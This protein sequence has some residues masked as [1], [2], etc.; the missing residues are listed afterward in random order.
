MSLIDS[1]TG[2]KRAVLGLACG[3]LCLLAFSARAVAQ[4]PTPSEMETVAGR[5]FVLA[6]PDTVINEHD[7]NF[8]LHKYDDQ[9]LICV[10][11]AVENKMTINGPGG[12]IRRD[13]PLAANQF[14]TIDLMKDEWRSAYPISWEVGKV[15]SSAFTVTA[16]QPVIVYCMMLTEF[17]A[18]AWTPLPVE[19]WGTV[20]YAAAR[21]G[22]WVFDLVPGK[23]GYEKSVKPA[24]GE[25][26]I[27]AAFDNTQVSFSTSE[28]LAQ[29][30]N[31]SV[32]LN[33]GQTY[34][35]QSYVNTDGIALGD[36]QPDLGGTRIVATKPISVI[37]GNT[38]AQV[39]SEGEGLTQNPW[40]N[41]LIEAVPPIEQNGTEFVFLPTWDAR[42]P[43]G[44]YL[45]YKR[46]AE[47]VRLYA[48]HNGNTEGFYTTGEPN[49]DIPI[50]PFAQSSVTEF[51]FGTVPPRYF[52]TN[53]PAMAMMNSAAAVRFNGFLPPKLPDDPDPTEPPTEPDTTVTL[54]RDYE[55]WGAYMVE[56]VP[57]EQWTTYAP[58]W[59]PAYSSDMEHYIN[60]VTDSANASSILMESG[61]P[62]FFNRGPI[63]TTGLI[64][65]TMSVIP[66]T[67]H[68]L[69][70]TNGGK[71][72]AFAYGLMRGQEQYIYIPGRPPK[73]PD[74][75]GADAKAEH[76]EYLAASYGYPLSPGR[77][78]LAAPDTLQITPTMGCT[79]LSIDVLATNANPVGLRVIKLEPATNARIKS[80]TPSMYIA[81]NVATIVVEPI[82]KSQSAS[83]TVVIIDRTGHSWSVPYS[84]VAEAVTFAPN[85]MLDFGEQ[86]VNI[87]ARRDITITNPVDKTLDITKLR[88]R[89]GNEDFSIVSSSPAVPTQLAKGA[90]MTVT[91][92]AKPTRPGRLYID[93]LVVETACTT[94]THPVRMETAEPF[95]Y[96]DDLA[97]GSVPLFGQRDLKLALCNIGRGLVTFHDSLGNDVIFWDDPHFIVSDVDKAKLR[98]MQLGPN[99]CDTIY[100]R[101]T[102]TETGIFR[103]TAR[104]IA[105]TRQQRD[106]SVWTAVVRIPGPQVDG[107]DFGTRWLTANDPCTKNTTLAYEDSIVVFNTGSSEFEVVSLT[108]SGPDVDAG[109]FALDNTDPGATVKPGDR[110]RAVNG[111]DTNYRYQKVLFKPG[112]ERNDYTATVSMV[113]VNPVS[114]IQNTV[115]NVLVGRGVQSHLAATGHVF[116]TVAFTTSGATVV[117]GTI[118]FEVKPTRPTTIT[119]VQITPNTG[120]FVVTNLADLKRVWQPGERGTIELEFR[121]TAAGLRN[122]QIAIIGDQS[123]CDESGGALVG[124]TTGGL[125]QP[126]DSIG[127]AVNNIDF[128]PV[129]G[130]HDTTG[131]IT[132]RN[133]G[134][135]AVT[136]TGVTLVSG[137]PEFSAGA[138][139]SP[140]TI[141][142]GG[143][144]SF[145]VTFSP[146]STASFTGQV[147][148]DIEL[149]GK[150]STITRTSTVIGSGATLAATATIANDLRAVSGEELVVPIALTT[151]VNAAKV[152]ELD[153]VVRYQRGMM[154][155]LTGDMARYTAGTLLAGWNAQVVSH[156]K[157]PSDARVM[158]LTLRAT[159]PANTF[160]SGTGDLLRIPFRTLIGDTLRSGLPFTI[161]SSSSRCV[162]FATT[163][164]YAVLDSVCG[165][166]FRLVEASAEDY[167][168][169]QNAPNPFNPSTTIEFG[170]G[171]DAQTTL[172]VYDAQGRR[173]A[174]LVDTYLKPGR[175]SVVWD[176][177]SMPSGL[178]YYR[179]TSNMWSQTNTMILQK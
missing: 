109:Y 28:R 87:P 7:H 148:F 81:S 91:I 168:L 74:D 15:V 179:L 85:V 108:I 140:V 147:R 22:E 130:C 44:L 33:A 172:V 39:L 158:I 61:N 118:D 105:N 40:R 70:S 112:Q 90:S 6:F 82:D 152:S 122:A 80:V 99:E 17:G 68:W 171:L 65:G 47:F 100:V 102:A 117:P 161:S 101:F 16:D 177:S 144:A 84:Y 162:A 24:P 69:R 176:A 128:G 27:V 10:F 142:A 134:N 123:K 11:S 132:V 107:V 30:Y 88:M 95:L 153:I 150:D 53:Q 164:G 151:P 64:W 137:A 32:T 71:F 115:E 165:L 149:S 56:M 21:D 141:P 23:D 110:V 126:T 31:R 35:I 113:V 54:S 94:L 8:V 34:T 83:G 3:I 25:F 96:M 36:E 160:V 173:V 136:V 5:T 170:V 77:N 1:M 73:P 104:A 111:A 19:K 97:F 145:P 131:S 13:I 66:G 163:P 29:D 42:R 41:M 14:T 98:A 93:S 89:Y 52:K 20:Y 50:D 127:A 18:E 37:S 9:I 114:G 121:P 58:Y 124:F 62:F 78:V 4:Q 51:R 159:A 46:Q 143:S 120:E 146:S 116:D 12:Y 2:A 38:R 156:V 106:T 57:R 129:L 178:Y 79:D 43:E 174:T 63:G 154:I 92:E 76:R 67:T 103:T 86:T 55:G 175:Y 60:V 138:L 49:A 157:D 166:S 167:I 125:P 45:Q 133:T 139:A 26:C 72:Y 169:K 75:P 48:T 59:A 155:A 135:V 119:D